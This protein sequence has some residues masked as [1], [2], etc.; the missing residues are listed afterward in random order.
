MKKIFIDGYNVINTWPNLKKVIDYSYEAARQGLIEVLQNF[1]NFD[2][3]NIEIVFDAHK[4]AGNLEK[5]DIIDKK[6]TVVFTKDGETA[7]SY[8]ERKVN[9]LGRRFEIWVVT[10]DWL[11]QQTIFQRGA[12]R[13][14]SLEFY[15]QMV[16]MKKVIKSETERVT[17]GNKNFLED[18]LD[19]K[20]LD[21]LNKII[22]SS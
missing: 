9:E 8:I 2:D 10:S 19:K 21:E 20:V 7:D 14:S 1:A 6:L 18:S 12:T 13:I 22:R 5:K 17:K 16:Q 11:E 3:C 4:V 15:H